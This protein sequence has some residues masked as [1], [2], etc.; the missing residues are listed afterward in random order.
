MHA[1]AGS[2]DYQGDILLHDENIEQY[3]ETELAA[4][5]AVLAQS[6]STS[7]GFGIPELIAM[8][9]HMMAEPLAECYKQVNRYIELLELN[10]LLNRSTQ[11]LS[12]G[13]LQRVYFAKCLAQLNVFCQ[14]NNGL[15]LLDEPTSA[16]DLAIN[17][18]Y[19]NW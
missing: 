7:F 15:M 10:H 3:D 16:L 5:R 18:A 4:K 14:Q 2:I 19:Y 17:T 8:G 11:Q 9:R 1:I 6:H 13:E 12:G